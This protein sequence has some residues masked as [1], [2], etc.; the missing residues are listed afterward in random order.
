MSS[1]IDGT[2]RPRRLAGAGVAAVDEWLHQLRLALDA[3]FD[4]LDGVLLEMSATSMKG[5]N[6][7]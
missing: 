3:N 6:E 1:R 4:R 7:K 5:E 2:R